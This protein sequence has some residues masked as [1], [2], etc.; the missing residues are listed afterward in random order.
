M[1]FDDRRKSRF[2]VAVRENAVAVF[3]EGGARLCDLGD[4]LHGI[5]AEDGRGVHDFQTEACGI[6]PV[7]R[8]VDGFHDGRDAVVKRDRRRAGIQKS[9]ALS[10]KKKFQFIN[11]VSVIRFGNVSQ[12]FGRLSGNQPGAADLHGTDR[13]SSRF[14]QLF[15]LIV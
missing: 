4:G 13:I 2:A 1:R 10:I 7:I 15:I 3:D 12:R 6:D 9:I 8:F 14:R 5:V 11:V